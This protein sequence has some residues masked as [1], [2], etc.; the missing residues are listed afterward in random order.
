[1]CFVWCEWSRNELMKQTP[2][3]LH[4]A[5]WSCTD[6]GGH[7]G[8][9]GLAPNLTD[10]WRCGIRS[11]HRHHRDRCGDLL[12]LLLRL[13]WSL[14]RELLHGHNGNSF[15]W[16]FVHLE[17][18]K[19]S[20]CGKYVMSLLSNVNSKVFHLSLSCSLPSCSHWSSLL[21]LLQQLLDTST[22]TK[23]VCVLPVLCFI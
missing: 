2:F 14:E 18:T 20:T 19:Q 4:T 21:R 8:P 9:D 23:W 17:T 6:C 11:S 1:M 13:L 3:L 7:P 16:T 5:M 22:E 10:P 15:R 12:H